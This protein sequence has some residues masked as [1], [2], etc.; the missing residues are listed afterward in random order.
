MK[1]QLVV[2]AALLLATPVRAVEIYD[3]IFKQ[4]TLSGVTEGLNYD[5]Q[6][7][8][9]ANPE[10]GA[11]HTGSVELDLAADDMATLKFVQGDQ[12]KNLGAFPATVGNPIIMYFVETVLRDVAHEAGGSPFYIRNRIKDS[13]ITQAPITEQTVTFSGHDM[14]AQ[15]ITL[16]PFE[17]DAS[18]DR[19]GIYGD[20]AITFTMSEDV[21]GWYVSLAATTPDV[22]GMPGYRN[23]LTLMPE[24]DE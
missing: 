4:G 24:G 6:I 22:D 18:Y 7:I 9:A 19:M 1:I 13:L 3:L 15:Q 23:V 5:R 16:R 14:T 20:L 10:Y 2:A 11:R 8:V 17:D 12:Y 21:P